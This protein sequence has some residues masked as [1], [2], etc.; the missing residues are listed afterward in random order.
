LK[1]KR[2]AP[3]PLAHTAG[4]LESGTEANA[5]FYTAPSG[6]LGAWQA[7]NWASRGPSRYRIPHAGLWC[8][9]AMMT[10]YRRFICK[11]D[12]DWMTVLPDIDTCQVCYDDQAHQDVANW[13]K[14]IDQ[15]AGRY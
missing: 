14:N 15:S 5:P 6:R 9:D 12:N 1:A 13:I 3:V 8:E 2:T 7:R 10:K 4:T 11:C